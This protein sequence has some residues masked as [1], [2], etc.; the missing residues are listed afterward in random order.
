MSTISIGLT[1]SIQLEKN[2][3]ISM[4][5]PIQENEHIWVWDHYFSYV[6]NLL[7]ENDESLELLNSLTDWSQDFAKNMASSF[8]ELSKNNLLKPS[9][10]IHITPHLENCSQLY[11]IE[12]SPQ[13]GYWPNVHI[14]ISDD[15]NPADIRDSVIG[16][17]EFFLINNQNFYRELPLHMLAMRKFYQDEIHYSDDTSISQAPAYAFDTAS[18]FFQSLRNT[19]QATQ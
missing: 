6:L 4:E 7:S 8:D 2:I 16:L 19:E 18:K 9:Q 17:A 11:F 1:D 14:K 13:E 12:I 5:N 15:A 10:H 3:M